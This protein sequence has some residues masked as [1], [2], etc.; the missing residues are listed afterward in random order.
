MN[1]PGKGRITQEVHSGKYPK[2]TKKSFRRKKG[3]KTWKWKKRGP[4]QIKKNFCAA[5]KFGPNPRENQ[6]EFLKKGPTLNEELKKRGGKYAELKE[7]SSGGKKKIHPVMS[8]P[9]RV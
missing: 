5:K 6:S 3:E 4:T 1:S 2:K 9:Y 7:R 8:K